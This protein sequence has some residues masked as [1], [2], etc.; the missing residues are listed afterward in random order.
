[1]SSDDQ[2][3]NADAPSQRRMLKRVGGFV[4]RT[5]G[6]TQALEEIGDRIGEAAAVNNMKAERLTRLLESDPT[7]QLM[8][9]GHIVFKDPRPR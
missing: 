5:M 7:V 1:M 6:G 4:P 2:S 3:D 9:S 8:P